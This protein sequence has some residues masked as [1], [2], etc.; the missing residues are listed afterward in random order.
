MKE[1]KN[2]LISRVTKKNSYHYK[3]SEQNM[4]KKTILRFLI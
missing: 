2:L 3:W 1:K 4:I